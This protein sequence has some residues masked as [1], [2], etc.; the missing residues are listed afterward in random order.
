MTPNTGGPAFP[1]AAS[2]GDP[3]DGVYCQNGMTMLDYM[4]GQALAGICASQETQMPFDV[5]HRLAYDHA[6]AMLS[7]KARREGAV[8]PA[9]SLDVA[10]HERDQALNRMANLEAKAAF[11]EKAL[12]EAAATLDKESNPVATK[13]FAAMARSKGMA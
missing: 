2:T 9:A 7:E 12:R 10:A 1:L 13:L 5:V 4:A 8:Q 11:L 6:D 3:R